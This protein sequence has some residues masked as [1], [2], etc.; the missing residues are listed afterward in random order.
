MTGKKRLFE[1]CS[2]FK[3]D[4]LGVALGKALK[5]YNIVV[6]GLKTKVGKFWWLIPTSVEVTGEKLEGERFAPNPHPE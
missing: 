6:K 5:F 2:W 3:F 4:N 1:G